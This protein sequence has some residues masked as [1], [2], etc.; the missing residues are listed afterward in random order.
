[1]WERITIY[2]RHGSTSCR[3]YQIHEDVASLKE[4]NGWLLKEFVEIF[5][6]EKIVVPKFRPFLDKYT[7]EVIKQ[8]IVTEHHKYL[9]N[10]T[11]TDGDYLVGITVLA[12][13][14][15]PRRLQI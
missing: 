10:K 5:L 9:N 12:T 13:G 6:G 14:L 15:K 11:S 7:Y 4:Y 2:K 8:F 1:M 3:I